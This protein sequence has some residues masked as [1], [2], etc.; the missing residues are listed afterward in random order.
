[1]EEISGGGLSSDV[2]AGFA[3]WLFSVAFAGNGGSSWWISRWHCVGLEHWKSKLV[4]KSK[5]L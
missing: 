2:Q 5:R 4:G 1:M 3:F